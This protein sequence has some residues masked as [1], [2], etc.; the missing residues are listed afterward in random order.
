MAQIKAPGFDISQIVV[1]TGK[2]NAGESDPIPS[3]VFARDLYQAL[4]DEIDKSTEQGGFGGN[5]YFGLDLKGKPARSTPFLQVLADQ[6]LEPHGIRTGLLADL[7]K[8]KVLDA[9]RGRH[10]VD[11]RAF[12]LRDTK[13]GNKRT[14]PIFE[15][16]AQIVGDLSVPAMVYGLKVEAWPQDKSGYGIKL[17]PTP[18]FTAVHSDIFN[19]NGMVTDLVKQTKMVF[20]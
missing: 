20:L 6:I 18:E 14:L 19:E 13:G 17:S 3:E 1:L 10:P 11:T 9:I 2:T 5:T 15:E 7:N 4:R 16:L 12:V 8:P